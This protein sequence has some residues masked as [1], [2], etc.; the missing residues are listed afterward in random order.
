[1]SKTKVFY[2]RQN[3]HAPSFGGSTA[4]DENFI[5]SSRG[6]AQVAVMQ[7]TRFD[8]QNLSSIS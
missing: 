1:M 4:T 3:T 6:S 7:A 5:P 2:G 8:E